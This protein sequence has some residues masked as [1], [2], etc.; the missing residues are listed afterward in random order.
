[1]A[2]M[3]KTA[4][5][6]SIRR[7]WH[8]QIGFNQN[9]I[10]IRFGR[11]ALTMQKI[12]RSLCFCSTVSILAVCVF[13]FLAWKRSYHFMTSNCF[14]CGCVCRQTKPLQTIDVEMAEK[15]A[16]APIARQSI[17][18]ERA[19]EASR[20]KYKVGRLE[21]EGSKTFRFFFFSLRH[22]RKFSFLLI[23]YVCGASCW[24]LNINFWQLK[25]F[26]LSSGRCWRCSF[27]LFAFR[28]LA[29]NHHH[30]WSAPIRVAVVKSGQFPHS[31]RVCA[32]NVFAR[33]R[34]RHF[35]KC[36]YLTSQRE[37][38]ASARIA[39]AFAH[40]AFHTKYSLLFQDF[41]FQKL[42][43][44]LG[45]CE[46]HGWV[47][48]PMPHNHALGVCILSASVD[49]L[50]QDPCTPHTHS[51]FHYFTS[52][53]FF[54]GFRPLSFASRHLPRQRMHI[55]KLPIRWEFSFY[56]EHAHVNVCEKIFIA[57][58]FSIG[59]PVEKFHK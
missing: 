51:S 39:R 1:M 37:Y 10:P 54:T 35:Y 8:I 32:R 15:W 41:P 24:I 6:W 3:P 38:A 47:C 23:V 42:R 2:E 50:A 31:P 20:N 30:R 59:R 18:V 5:I 19:K 29:A 33:R 55:S 14:V 27:V 13:F 49:P 4:S 21:C 56:V 17:R 11:N 52:S 40:T 58:H 12:E 9:A 36:I 57:R 16:Q 7:L 53:P 48:V 45:W 26:T 44:C 22:I 34:R 28:L 25:V 46:L 43:M